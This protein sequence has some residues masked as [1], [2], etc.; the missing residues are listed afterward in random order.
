MKIK[1]LFIPLLSL[2]SLASCNDDFL[3][4]T[5]ET[6]R[7]TT[8]FYQ[9]AADFNNAVVGTYN[10]LKLSGVYGTSL[11]WMG[12]VSTD[13]TDFGVNTRQAVNVDN[14]Q[15]VDHTYTS[16]NDIIFSAWRDH[17]RGISRANA[18]LTRIES[19]KIADNLKM[20][21]KGEAQF[22]RALFY[23]DL[24]RLFGDIPL[25]TTEITTPDGASSLTRTPA[26]DVYKLIISD[27]QS[28][29]QAL[30]ISYG[31]ADIGRVP[32]GT[33]KALLGKV[34]L[35]RKD[36]ATAAAKLKEVITS[37]KYQLLPK[38]ADVFSYATPT[39]AEIL[40]NVQYKS[41]NTGQGS[42]FGPVQASEGARITGGSMRYPTADM[43][44]A[45]EA[46]DQRKSFSMKSSYLDATG[47]LVNQRYVSK[48]VQFGALASDSDIDFPVLRYADVLLMYAEALNEVDFNPEAVTYLNQ[49]RKRAGL[50]DTKAADQASF[51]LA[52]EQERRVEFAFENQRWFDLVRTGRYVTVMNAKGLKVQDFNT[53]F[54]IP[55]REIDLN[56]SLK[57]NPG[58]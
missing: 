8:N 46:G 42:G 2:L 35:T 19:A 34:Y 15:F 49:V 57:Q 51:R 43:E 26:E 25:I 39:N 11:Y 44:T 16:L 7:N 20:Q 45:Y 58:Y 6:D 4:L 14:F 22:L 23:F 5:P 13:N 28:A 17:Y 37:G 24:V 55:Q 32:Q 29:E 56:K 53:L 47:Q 40:F 36:W 9:T 41:G 30:P 12:E 18:I 48:Y 27:L 3:S 10:A 52:I 54:L 31:T 21:Y 33:A 38:Y 1:H 50:A